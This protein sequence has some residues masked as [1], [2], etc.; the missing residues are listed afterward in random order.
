MHPWLIFLAKRLLVLCGQHLNIANMMTLSYIN[1]TLQQNS[2]HSETISYNDDT[3]KAVSWEVS[4]GK[5]FQLLESSESE[6]F[7]P[8][9]EDFHGVSALALHPV[10]HDLEKTHAGGRDRDD[11]GNEDT[12]W[13][14][15]SSIHAILSSKLPTK[16]KSP[17]IED[18]DPLAAMKEQKRHKKEVRACSRLSSTSST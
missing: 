15:K 3:S 16:R 11:E 13:A 6:G 17:D 2:G 12:P 5:F 18:E 1:H 7:I 14:S 10:W 8:C 4:L 9:Y